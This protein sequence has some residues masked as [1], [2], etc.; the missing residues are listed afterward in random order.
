[1]DPKSFSFRLRVFPTAKLRRIFSREEARHHWRAKFLGLT[2]HKQLET[3]NNVHVVVNEH[4][5]DTTARTSAKKTSHL[6][7]PSIVILKDLCSCK[8][9]SEGVE[10]SQEETNQGQ[11]Q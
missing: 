3:A 5:I 4:R 8:N 7:R 6:S 2:T 10:D 11:S 9:E 1:M